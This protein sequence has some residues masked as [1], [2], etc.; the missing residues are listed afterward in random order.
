MS[1]NLS[2]NFQKPDPRD[3]LFISHLAVTPETPLHPNVIVNQKISLPATFSLRASMSPILNQGS[4]G[5]CVSN[6][7]AL[8]ISTMTKNSINMS[9]LFHYALTRIMEN[10]ALNNDSGQTIRDAANTIL[11]YG[12]P[13]E[14]E[15]PYV[16]SQFAV[17]PPLT[18]FKASNKFKSFVYTF[19]NSDLNSLKQCLSTNQKPII[20]GFMVYS[21]FMTQSVASTGVVPLPDTRKEKLLGGHCITII[22]YD[23]AKNVFICANSWGTGWGDKGYCYMPYAYLTNLALA[24]DFCYLTLTN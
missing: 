9:R 24:R 12:V 8:S 6:A 23:D 22:G 10:T 16:P 21:S 13:Q 4:V 18:A 20:F 1:Y 7:F 3:Y 2:Y 14:T 19:V 5:S 11:N 15:W 17:F